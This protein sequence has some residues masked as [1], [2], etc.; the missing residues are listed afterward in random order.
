MDE[1]NERR[2]WKQLLE[3]SEKYSA[4]YFYLAPKFP[5]HLEFTDKVTVILCQNGAVGKRK[6]NLDLDQVIKGLEK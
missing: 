2:I 5:R 4:Q 1:R 3:T 6:S